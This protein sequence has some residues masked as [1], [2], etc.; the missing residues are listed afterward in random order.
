LFAKVSRVSIF[1][2]AIE[3]PDDEGANTWLDL[4]S[5]NPDQLKLLIKRLIRLSIDQGLSRPA[6]FN[7]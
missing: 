2:F 6:A 5:I 3:S 7:M 4:G 1:N